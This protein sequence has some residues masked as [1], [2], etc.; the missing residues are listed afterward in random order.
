MTGEE[1]IGECSLSEVVS[2]NGGSR[3]H[4][5]RMRPPPKC[6]IER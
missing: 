2:A 3:R 1:F 6:L 4:R 5:Q